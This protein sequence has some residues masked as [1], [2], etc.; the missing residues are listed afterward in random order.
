MEN[1]LLLVLYTATIV[2]VFGVATLIV[3]YF[4]KRYPTFRRKNRK[5]R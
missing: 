5:I 1:V 3:E 2:A 4:E